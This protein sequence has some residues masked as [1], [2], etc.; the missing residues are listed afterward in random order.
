MIGI[1]FFFGLLP[2]GLG[3][4]IA[5]TRRAEKTGAIGHPVNDVSSNQGQV[6]LRNKLAYVQHQYGRQRLS[7]ADYQTHVDR[8]LDEWISLE[9]PN[10]ISS[11]MGLATNKQTT[12]QLPVLAEDGHPAEPN[13]SP[14]PL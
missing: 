3:K 7:Q 12:K 9:K 8:L 2:I 10:L 4:L 6:L 11:P 14:P 5:A 13:P 1:A